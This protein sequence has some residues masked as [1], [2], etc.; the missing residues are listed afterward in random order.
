MVRLLRNSFIAI[1]LI[2]LFGC[3][4]GG[5]GGGGGDSGKATLKGKVTDGTGTQQQGLGSLGGSGTVAAASKVRV[6]EV[7]A[8]GSLT[9]VAEGQL[10]SGGSYSLE[11]PAGKKKLIVQ[12]IDG[13]GSVISSAIVEATGSAQ[14]TVTAPPMDTETSVEAEVFV[15]MVAQGTAVAEANAIDL[16]ARIN[17]KV[18]EAVKASS[19]SKA[20]I[21]V[22]AE[23]TIA[24]QRTQLEA[25]AQ[26]GVN[27]TQS[28]LFDAYLAAAQ[29]LNSSL[30]ASATASAQAYAEFYA[31][32]ESAQQSVGTTPRQRAQ[33]ES[34][35]GM[36][37]RGTARGRT[38]ASASSDAVVDA[39]IRS[40][41]AL[42]AR[43]SAAAAEATFKAAAA[44]G[45][46]QDKVNQANATLK[47]SISAATTA[48]AAAQAYAA[49]STS[50]TGGADV[51][52]GALGAMLEVNAVNKVTLQ[53]A[54]DASVTA[55]SQ[56]DTALNTALAANATTGAF[57]AAALADAVVSAYST[58]ATT[59]QGQA[60]ALATFGTKAQPTVDVLIVVNASFRL[61]S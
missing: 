11:V 42:E 25:F 31:G 8:N 35:A 52:A 47:S 3:G 29:K 27:T 4:E 15:E 38:G 41:A 12:A 48:Q 49:Y 46:A 18:A 45:T 54:V 39:A 16:R 34:C 23:A 43:F 55:A 40:A 20:K 56:L 17:S 13:S 14:A 26:S 60:T 24:A 7:G 57:N 37:F 30:D 59:V 58:Y 33:A 2:A 6:S 50:V 61:G 28:A 21:K 1:S 51:S 32:I 36:S 19:D 22:L 5:G 10:Q 53:A 9:L 44:V